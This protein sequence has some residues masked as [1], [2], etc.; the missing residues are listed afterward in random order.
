MV[1]ILY[2]GYVIFVTEHHHYRTD[3]EVYTDRCQ[4]QDEVDAHTIQTYTDEHGPI[5]GVACGVELLRR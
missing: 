4:L 3:T 1:L 5:D 2:W